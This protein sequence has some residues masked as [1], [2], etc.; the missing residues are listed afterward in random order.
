[1]KKCDQNFLNAIAHCH[2]PRPC[3]GNITLL[4]ED[5]WREQQCSAHDGTPYGGEMFHWIAHRDDAEPCAL[6]CRGTPQHLGQSPEPTVSLD[7]DER[8]VVA[9]LAARVSDGTRCRPGSLD[10]CI[11]GRCQPKRS[12]QFNLVQL[13]SELIDLCEGFS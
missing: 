13:G 10:M 1:M 2:S 5:V 4:E 3:R 11:D 7:D 6:T 8:V 12:S 9:V